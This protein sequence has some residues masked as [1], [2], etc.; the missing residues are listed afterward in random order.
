MKGKITL[1]LLAITT[2]GYSQIPNGYYS[3][4]TGTGAILKT[5]LYNIIKGHTDKG[6]AGLYTTYQTSDIDNFYEK[7]G[8]IMDM[9][10]ENPEG[11]DPYN[12]GS[13]TTQRCG[14]Y[15]VEGDCYNREHMIPQSTFGKSAPMVNDAHHITPTDGKVNSLRN[16]YPHGKVNIAS[17]TTKNGGKLGSSA[18]P[19]YSG[20]VFEPIDE[21]KGDIARIYFYF[22]TRYENT[23]SG[24]PFDAFNSTS[25]PALNPAFIQLFAQW[26]KQDPVSAFEIQRNNAIYKIQNNRNPYIDH[27]EYVNQIWGTYL[28]NEENTLSYETSI[29]P[30]PSEGKFTI[31]FKEIGNYEVEIISI[32]GQKVAGLNVD[33]NETTVENLPKG[34]YLVKITRDYQSTTKK[35]IIN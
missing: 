14:N 35:L 7:D 10:S 9:Y 3:T 21:F 27:P 26:H 23:V 25:F 24:Y 8:T 2:L 6:Y 31:A 30:N 32:V 15:K 16:N 12:Y 17:T 4:A 20:T 28:T 18:I 13:D 29:F 34:A 11:S 5:Q 22:V 19:G 1:L 33:G